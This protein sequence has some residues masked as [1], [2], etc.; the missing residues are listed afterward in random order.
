MCNSAQ[1][2]SVIHGVSAEEPMDDNGE[3]LDR[4]LTVME[5]KAAVCN[6][7]LKPKSIHLEDPVTDGVIQSIQ[8][9]N[10]VNHYIAPGSVPHDRL[11]QVSTLNI[12][13]RMVF[14][15]C[16]YSI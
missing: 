3:E 11:M 10:Q 7:R 14:K 12:T 4:L 6:S 1:E 16:V 8:D 15:W 5:S 9:V 2:L 13:L